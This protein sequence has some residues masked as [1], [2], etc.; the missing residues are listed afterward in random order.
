MDDE[1]EGSW[2]PAAPAKPGNN[3]WPVPVL[4]QPL[5]RGLGPPT[6]NLLPCGESSASQAELFSGRLS[7]SASAGKPPA[8]ST[9]PLWLHT[10]R[11]D[12]H[13]NSSTHPE[14]PVVMF[15]GER[16]VGPPARDDRPAHRGSPFAS[17][18]GTESIH[19]T[20][21]KVPPATRIAANH[22][23]GPFVHLFF[24]YCPHSSTLSGSARACDTGRSRGTVIWRYRSTMPG[25]RLDFVAGTAQGQHRQVG[26]D[27]AV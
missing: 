1:Q 24:R 7:P 11:R 26:L 22:T 14:P 17:R 18:S 20:Q 2:K 25:G 6:V 4:A 8:W 21:Q 15:P 27:P 16:L 19:I 12:D 3:C 5:P 10:A 9:L 13:S 23:G